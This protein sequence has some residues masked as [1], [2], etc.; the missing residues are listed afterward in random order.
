MLTCVFIL[1][2]SIAFQQAYKLANG[3]SSITD[4]ANAPLDGFRFNTDVDTSAY[5]YQKFGTNY[6]LVL[7]QKVDKNT[8][9]SIVPAQKVAIWF[10]VGTVNKPKLYLDFT[11]DVA[12]TVSYD[13]SGDGWTV[14]DPDSTSAGKYIFDQP[15]F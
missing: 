14:R 7:N 15:L 9:A 13:S 5:L 1:E 10:K 3:T 6:Q 12:Q 8:I 2:K 11:K 4:D